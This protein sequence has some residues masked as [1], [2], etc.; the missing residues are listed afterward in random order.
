MEKRDNR[1]I[2]DVLTEILKN[3]ELEKEEHVSKKSLDSGFYCCYHDY[4]LIKFCQECRCLVCKKCMLEEK[5]KGHKLIDISEANCMFSGDSFYTFKREHLDFETE[6]VKCLD[7][8]EQDLDSEIKELNELI[9]TKNVLRD[10]FSKEINSLLNSINVLEKINKY[11]DENIE[12]VTSET[13]KEVINAGQTFMKLDKRVLTPIRNMEVK[14]TEIIKYVDEHKNTYYKMLS[15]Y[16]YLGYSLKNK[17]KVEDFIINAND[18]MLKDENMETIVYA[19]SLNYILYKDKSG[20][21]KPPEFN[22]RDVTISQISYDIDT[23]CSFPGANNMEFVVEAM[24]QP[25]NKILNF[26]ISEPYK[27]VI[28]TDKTDEIYAELSDEG[29]LIWANTTNKT[30]NI[31]NLNNKRAEV[32]SS[33]PSECFIAIYDNKVHIGKKRSD[34]L[35][36]G[37][38]ESLYTE[39][40]LKS[41]KTHRIIPVEYYV[42]RTDISQ[43]TGTVYYSNKANQIVVLDLRTYTCT[44]ENKAG[45][46]HNIASFTG[47]NIPEVRCVTHFNDGLTRSVNVVRTDWASM[48]IGDIRRGIEFVIPSASQPWNIADGVVIDYDRN[49]YGSGKGTGPSRLEPLAPVRGR[50][51]VRVWHDVFLVHSSDC[52]TARRIVIP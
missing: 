30:L 2:V 7:E 37:T 31:Y 4:E 13:V 25:L 24:K 23:Y 40:N 50:A 36:V 17:E 9:D 27:V 14:F 47:I 35:L 46:N 12:Q 1:E 21:K 51:L 10:S 15:V 33:F 42:A 11:V 3:T 44:V 45:Q 28:P 26:K 38:I 32:I 29:D 41:F 8:L 22:D 49:I 18:L 5:H 43:Q 19:L 34:K 52:W 6:A 20:I 48:S 16:N 39:K